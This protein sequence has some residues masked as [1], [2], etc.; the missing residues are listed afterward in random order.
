MNPFGSGDGNSLA[1]PNVNGPTEPERQHYVRW[2]ATWH[3]VNPGASHTLCNRKVGA[4]PQRQIPKPGGMSHCK[5]CFNG[6][7]SGT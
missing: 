5:T 2:G 4:N 1:G 3:V 6:R 7:S